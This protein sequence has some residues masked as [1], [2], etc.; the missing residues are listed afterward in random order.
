MANGYIG[1]Y[2]LTLHHVNYTMT[3]NMGVIAEFQ[4]ATGTDFPYICVRAINAFYRSRELDENG[5]PIH[6]L[7]DRAEMMADAVPMD[8]AAH[9]FYIAAKQKNPR[10]EFGEIQEA[11]ILEGVVEES[12]DIQSYPILFVELAQFALVG[13]RDELKKKS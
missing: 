3:V 9:L 13:V 5:N 7:L 4:S 11:L 8:T 1:E 10:V 6:S 2:D 12:E